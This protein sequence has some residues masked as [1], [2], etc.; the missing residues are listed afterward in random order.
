MSATEKVQA[1]PTLQGVAATEE[2]TAMFEPRPFGRVA[3]GASGAP[4]EPSTGRQQAAQWGTRLG[5]RFDRVA[6][7]NAAAGGQ[8][9]ALGQRAQRRPIIQAKLTVGP[10][11]DK[12]EQEA[13]RVAQ[14][15]AK[16]I[17]HP[18]THPQAG[19]AGPATAGSP[20]TPI[21][22]HQD[23][24]AVGL[25][26]PAP[27]LT[28]AGSVQPGH[29]SDSLANWSNPGIA[30]SAGSALVQCRD[31]DAMAADAGDLSQSLDPPHADSAG[32][33]V[34]PP[35]ERAIHQQRGRG[36]SLPA[37]I[38]QPLER[39][40]GSDF[41]RV[42]IH[43]DG[44]A[45]RLNRA[46]RARAFTTGQDIFFRQG[47][48]RP[49]TQ[50]GNETLAHELTHVEQQEGEAGSAPPQTLQRTIY[51]DS[52]LART[53][54]PVLMSDGEAY[55]FLRQYGIHHTVARQLVD[56]YGEASS[57]PAMI[58]QLASMGWNLM[59]PADPWPEEK[60]SV[61][62]A[63]RPAPIPGGPPRPAP[64][65][66]GARPAPIP[67]RAIPA[68]IPGAPVP[69]PIPTGAPLPT[70]ATVPA[71]PTN[72]LNRSETMPTLP[73]GSAPSASRRKV[74]AKSKRERTKIGTALLRIKKQRDPLQAD[75]LH[76]DF[77]RAAPFWAERFNFMVENIGDDRVKALCADLGIR[78]M[79]DLK[80]LTPKQF[81]ALIDAGWSQQYERPAPEY[82]LP[83]ERMYDPLIT[84]QDSS[85]LQSTDVRQTFKNLGL[86]FRG[87]TRA[88]MSGTAP[89][90]E[91]GFKPR[92]AL[93]GHRSK[94]RGTVM[95]GMMLNRINRDFAS[96]TG[97]CVSR[98]I[99]GASKFPMTGSDS[100]HWLYIVDLNGL[101]GVDTERYQRELQKQGD[102]RALWRPGEKA[103]REITPDRVVAAVR[104]K[105]VDFNPN[106]NQRGDRWYSYYTYK[107]IVWNRS[108]GLSR[109]EHFQQTYIKEAVGA[110][111]GEL[112]KQDVYLDEDFA[113]QDES[114]EAESKTEDPQPT[115]R[116]RSQNPHPRDRHYHVPGWTPPADTLVINDVPDEIHQHALDGA[117]RF[118]EYIN[119][120]GM[121]FRIFFRDTGIVE[122]TAGNPLGKSLK[123]WLVHW[124]RGG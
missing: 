15:V 77:R 115:K 28:R 59:D 65:P 112:Q 31:Q 24:D 40:F 80:N 111:K 85:L 36:Q 73:F 101:T 21:P 17:A 98:T 52:N 90:F 88:P 9:S 108:G 6:V 97:V 23:G 11:N 113:M 87:D 123:V 45:D 66:G 116:A 12:Y 51:D 105:R 107:D 70:P 25:T 60:E 33:N 91:T 119:I 27:T 93:P 42:S 78:Q 67:G 32:S 110:I 75:D 4:V 94:V 41:S 14:Q 57:Q 58:A 10:A 63:P 20:V 114:K 109:L 50:Q 89:V 48:Y 92:F 47:E 29:A 106:A 39:S 118:G 104:F 7:A 43:A 46:I 1:E 102:E 81:K 96:E 117:F 8:Q 74:N 53:R 76:R 100:D 62:A 56:R 103:F 37:R 22:Q 55:A 44:Q 120:N 124:M 3:E 121:R 95:E 122:A 83:T 61:A 79:G 19:S 82:V 49:G 99:Q 68:P 26:A 71:S 13:D 18:A 2:E 16:T 54:S 69:A 34:A 35:L 64:I 30:S 38:R 72:R 86:A 5:H 84:R